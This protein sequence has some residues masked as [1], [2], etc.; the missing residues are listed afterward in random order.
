MRMRFLHTMLPLALSLSLGAQTLNA[1]KAPDEVSF[2]YRIGSVDVDPRL[3]P[4][5]ANL[6]KL[7]SILSRNGATTIQRIE[8]RASSSPDGPEVLNRQYAHERGERLM[9][10][11][12]ERYPSLPASLWQVEEIAEDW[13]GIAEYLRHST[14]DYKNEAMQIVRSDSRNKKAL[15]Q[16]LYAGEAWDDLY[17]YAF[18]WLR[19]VKLHVYY[20][21]EGQPQGTE[22]ALSESKRT[23]EGCQVGFESSSYTVNPDLFE[24]R[25][26]LAKVVQAIR[27]GQDSVRIRTYASP[28]GT[29]QTN[30]T[31]ARRRSEAVRDY[32]VRQAGLDPAAVAIE[33]IG[34][35]WDGF[36]AT[37]TSTYTGNDRESVLSIVNDPSR[38]A[39]AKEAALRKLDGGK[40]WRSLIQNQT[41]GLRRSEISCLPRTQR[42]TAKESKG[43]E[44]A[45]KEIV[46]PK[47]E[48]EEEAELTEEIPEEAVEV[49]EEKEETVIVTDEPRIE[50]RKGEDI[51]IKGS[52]TE[53]S[54]APISGTKRPL[55][56]ISTNLLY[57]AATAFN[58][59]LEVPINKHWSIFADGAYNEFLRK[60]ENGFSI[61]LADL[62]ANYYFAGEGPAMKGWFAAA[63]AG[64]ARYDLAPKDKGWTGEVYYLSL[65]GGYSFQ[66]GKKDS[67]W[68]LKLAG[69]FGPFYTDYT[70]SERI[71]T[72][73]MAPKHD[74]S[75]TWV[76]PTNLQASIVYIFQTK[77]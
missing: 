13:D 43:E 16:D 47:E 66:L 74:S 64:A 4:N 46:A 57:D 11:I 70:Y 10:S 65:G 62:G 38:G 37:I 73:D 41:D 20:N 51:I 45:E 26:D 59:G 5:A 55:F 36:V 39:D 6:A 18:P 7:D 28:D 67:N 40:T 50:I 49:E 22:A 44:V 17:K 33:N 56:A 76:L 60:G 24:N 34:E 15:L 58:I 8:L 2:R 12:K 42:T 77:K 1:Q 35:D 75:F 21:N 30:Q 32:L 71:S 25:A 54:A 52:E 3:N 9:N 27:D 23:K 53:E 72:G 69:G 19:A 61:M 68:R 31:I 29:I 14:E 63:A 48:L